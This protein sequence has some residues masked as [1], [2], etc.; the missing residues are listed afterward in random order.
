M[1]DG[2]LDADCE[3]QHQNLQVGYTEIVSGEARA[4]KPVAQ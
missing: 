3:T 1:A 4:D 2:H